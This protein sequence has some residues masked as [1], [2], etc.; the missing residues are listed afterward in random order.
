MTARIKGKLRRGIQGLEGPPGADGA[1]GAVWRGEYNPSTTYALNDQV[2][3]QLSTWIC[4]AITAGNAPPTLPTVQNFWWSLVAQAGGSFIADG[5]KGSIT[6]SGGG[7]AWSINDGV[8]TNSKLFGMPEATIKG[9]AAGAGTGVPQDLTAAQAQA[10]LG[11]VVTDNLTA[12]PYLT[13]ISDI[14]NHMPVNFFRFV[15]PAQAVGIRARTNADDLTAR[16]AEALASGALE[17]NLEPGRYN[18]TAAIAMSTANQRLRGA[19]SSRSEI[20]ITSTT[21]SALTLANGVPGYGVIGIKFTRVGTPNS[22]SHGVQFLGTTDAST[23]YDVWAEGHFDNFIIGTCDTG[24][25][26]N[27]RANKALR[28]GVFQ[29][30]AITYGPSQWA[31]DNV[32]CDQNTVDGWRVQ[33]TA[34]PPG[35]ITGEMMRFKTFAN[36]GRG[37]HAI[38]NATTP[39]FD[40]RLT[41]AFLG[42]DAFGSVRLDTFGGKHRLNGFFERN[43]RDATGPTLGTPAS[44]AGVGIEVSVNNADVG[45][46]GSTI[47][48]NAL[49]GIIHNGG[50]LIVSGNHI[51]NNGQALT[52]GRRNGILSQGGNLT[53]VGNTVNNK[54]GNTS[55]LFGIATSHSNVQIAANHLSGNTSG[56][57]TLG[58]TTNAQVV[59]NSPNTQI[60]YLPGDI[61]KSGTVYANP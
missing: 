57:I 22:N 23:L 7:S 27:L 44:N 43:G 16:F 34:G 60:N 18:T 38:G 32:L 2:R 49:D 5:D 12:P 51:Y 41:D 42:S 59:G 31:V 30:N 36:G 14:L 15:T 29:T 21:A 40:V 24:T 48:D 50:D 52:A 58:A 39:I 9:R 19:G 61:N 28:Y 54:G 4:I 25:I 55:Q 35:M 45:V 17:I 47:D 8:V 53:V 6:T 10:V 3:H 46:Y 1:N 33:S 56:P 20:R 37:L 11:V 26:Q 13:T